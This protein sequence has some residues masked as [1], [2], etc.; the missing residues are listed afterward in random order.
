M[1]KKRIFAEFAL[2]GVIA[3]V[4]LVIA[5]PEAAG[6]NK[7]AGDNV[8]ADPK[9]PKASQAP[10]VARTAYVDFVKLLKNDPLFLTAQ[11]KEM[12]KLEID[13]REEATT[14]DA[15]H[16][17]DKK[18]LEA[19]KPDEMEYRDLM[20]DI[21]ESSA[22]SNRKRMTLESEAQRTIDEEAQKA[23]KRIKD[24]VAEISKTKGYS[25]VMLIS[26]TPAKGLKFDE[27]Q[28]QLLLSPMLIYPEEDDITKFVEKENFRRSYGYLE[29]GDSTAKEG[30]IENDGVWTEDD[31]GNKTQ[32]AAKDKVNNAA[33]VW[34]E[35]KVGARL[36]LKCAVTD[37]DENDKRVPAKPA[38]AEVEWTLIRLQTGTLDE[39][40]GVYTA[41]DAMP[42]AGDIVSIRVSCKKAPYKNTTIR[43]R[44]IK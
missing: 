15:K 4:C 33:D 8:I 16:A 37:L 3:A 11:L 20:K 41:P 13:M 5:W 6:V 44:L 31:K 36:S 17:N 34:F 9:D 25:Q 23:F 39:K 1:M 26:S 43:V 19:I 10:A 14:F 32:R 21:I 24:L 2:L 38:N 42:A 30:T 22:K 18:R 40:T 35:C 29:I 27:L 12:H 7:V 28:K